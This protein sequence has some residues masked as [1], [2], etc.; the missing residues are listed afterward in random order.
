MLEEYNSENV[1]WVDCI[2][3]NINAIDLYTHALKTISEDSGTCFEKS[4]LAEHGGADLG[5]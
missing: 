1:F 2:E 3:G 4:Q 5:F